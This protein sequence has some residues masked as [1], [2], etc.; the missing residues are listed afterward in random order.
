MNEVRAKTHGFAIITAIFI[1][2]VLAALGAFILNVF[3]NQ[4]IGAALDMQGVKA[5]QAARAG[6]EWGAYQVQATPAYNFSYGVSNTAV[7]Y[8]NANTRACP[9]PTN[10]TPSAIS[11]SGFTVQCVAS[12]DASGGPTVFVITSTACNQPSAIGACP[13]TTNPNNLYVE[14]RLEVTL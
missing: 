7:G 3:T 9:S 11:L 5:Y 12:A 8:A 14:R 10:F 1:L 4:Q 6:V 2:V 13:N